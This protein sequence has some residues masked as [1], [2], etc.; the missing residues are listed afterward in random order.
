MTIP[1]SSSDLQSERQ[2]ETQLEVH[3]TTSEHDTQIATEI[4][5]FTRTIALTQKSIPTEWPLEVYFLIFLK[6]LIIQGHVKLPWFKAIAN[7]RESSCLNVPVNARLLVA[8]CINHKCGG[9]YLH[10]LPCRQPHYFAL[11]LN[12]CDTSWF[13]HSLS[14]RCKRAN[15]NGIDAATMQ[16]VRKASRQ[17]HFWISRFHTSVS[18]SFLHIFWLRKLFWV[19]MPSCGCCNFHFL[20]HSCLG[21]G[22]VRLRLDNT[23]LPSEAAASFV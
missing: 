13:S 9:H 3:L 20:I 16:A 5:A 10:C 11:L 8:I 17:S 14:G 15:Y 4:P 22:R 18:P 23:I 6:V 12:V 19:S 7:I 21:R 1:S 2:D